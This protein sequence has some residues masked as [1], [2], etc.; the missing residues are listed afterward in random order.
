MTKQYEEI[1]YIARGDYK[2]MLYKCRDTRTFKVEVVKRIAIPDALEGIPGP[3]LKEI[4][5][6]QEF[7]HPNIAKLLEVNNAEKNLDLVFEFMDN[8]LHDCIRKQPRDVAAHHRAILFQILS[9]L[10]YY[11]SR[12]VFGLDLKRNRILV[13]MRRGT[14]KIADFGERAIRIVTSQVNSLIY[15]APETILGSTEY[16][17]SVD[18][19]AAGCIFYEMF[20]SKPLFSGLTDYQTLF[21]IFRYFGV[22]TNETWP[23]VSS[24]QFYDLHTS[25]FAMLPYIKKALLPYHSTVIEDAGFD[26]LTIFTQALSEVVIGELL[27]IARS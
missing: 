12:T 18:I 3:L 27:C 26:L 21:E 11:H 24:L 16:S 5:L 19:W 22:P 13:D 4:S 10:S 7:D 6:L 23:G 1:D 15:R 2:C 20:M 14:V 17:G 8:N 25:R 9:G